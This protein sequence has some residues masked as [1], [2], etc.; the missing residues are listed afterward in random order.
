[1]FHNSYNLGD[2]HDYIQSNYSSW[3]E[4]K[5]GIESKEEVLAIKP[6][7]LYD[8]SGITIST[9][10]FQCR[11]D[12]GQVGWIY[13]TKGTVKIT[14]MPIDKDLDKSIDLELSTYDQEIQGEVFGFSCY[15]DGECI[16]SCGGFYGRDIRKNGMFDHIP[17]EFEILLK[18]VVELEI[19]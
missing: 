8:H 13:I 1:C 5:K 9:S 17:E 14:G 19:G 4:L 6:L 10:P 2:E 15:K 7:Y 12:S 16:D 11:W 18:E 3:E